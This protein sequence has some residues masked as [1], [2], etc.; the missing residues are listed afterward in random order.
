MCD[1]EAALVGSKDLGSMS[2]KDCTDSVDGSQG[3]GKAV[4]GHRT[5]VWV[6]RMELGSMCSDG[7]GS[8]HHAVSRPCTMQ[9]RERERERERNITKI[10]H[11]TINCCSQL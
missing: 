5:A 10:S 9:E 11:L 6:E 8:M 7:C 2:R 3:G 4:C 1:R